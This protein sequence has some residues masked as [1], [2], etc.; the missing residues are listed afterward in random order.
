MLKEIISHPDFD[1]YQT[2]K[3]G[4][5][6]LH[7]LTDVAAQDQ[8]QH[9][10]RFIELVASEVDEKR[11]SYSAP[12]RRRLDEAFA[13]RIA[14]EQLIDDQG[15]PIPALEMAARAGV[16]PQYLRVREWAKDLGEVAAY[17]TTLEKLP[18]GFQEKFAEQLAIC[19]DEVAECRT[20]MNRQ[21]KGQPGF[22]AR[23]H[24]GNGARGPEEG[25][26]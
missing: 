12:I 3:D 5:D 13:Q 1:P 19:H 23:Y 24:T 21:G 14:P 6:I 8:R 16:L 9:D 22:L 7:I 17:E 2:G 20:G 18:Q 15:A 11:S 25:R 4:Q 10:K 26:R